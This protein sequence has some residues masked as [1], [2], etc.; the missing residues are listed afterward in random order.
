MSDVHDR[1]GNAKTS[2]SGVYPEPG[3]YPVLEIDS[4]R[5]ID[6]RKGDKLFC[7]EFNILESRVEERPA[8]SSMSWMANLTKHDAAPGNVRK[9]LA[10]AAGVTVENVDP[11]GSAAAVSSHNPLHGRL[12]RLEAMMTKT[13]AGGD[14]TLCKFT[15]LPDDVQ[16]LRDDYRRAASFQGGEA[17]F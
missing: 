7:A 6:S 11:E 17:P 5:V 14:F 1:I 13:R 8:G 9:F 12:V 2:E 10:A 4:C 15:S 3:V 16:A